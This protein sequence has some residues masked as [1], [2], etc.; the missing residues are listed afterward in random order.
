M[1]SDGILHFRLSLDFVLK[2]LIWFRKHQDICVSALPAR[3]PNET[4]SI[5]QSSGVWG[6]MQ[7]QVRG[8]VAISRTKEHRI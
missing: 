8:C 1:L 6:F 4:I 7:A 2:M 3:G 5:R